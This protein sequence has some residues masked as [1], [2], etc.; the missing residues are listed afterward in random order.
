VS[1]KQSNTLNMD[2]Q[3]AALTQ[4]ERLGLLSGALALLL[5]LG[6]ALYI[7]TGPR[8][9]Y[10]QSVN[11]VKTLQNEL[12]MA[13]LMKKEQEMRLESQ[14]MLVVTLENRAAAFDLFSY[15][16]NV[17]KETGLTTGDRAL[18]ENLRNR[19]DLENQPAVD[20]TLTRVTLEELVNFLHKV[21]AS[22]NLIAVY[23]V[24]R[25]EAERTG[26]GLECKLTLI[27][28]QPPVKEP[29]DKVEN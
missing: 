25:L 9:K 8:N 23:K 27:S 6:L 20:L 3:S 18:L 4:K 12:A 26:Q 1:N 24:D 29:A 14:E 19:R 5:V 7:P 16:S 22:N 11:D 21:Y 13:T 2:E 17:L 28:L 10:M 15:L